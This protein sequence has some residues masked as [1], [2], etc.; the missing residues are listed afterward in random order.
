VVTPDGF[1]VED[2]GKGI[3]ETAMKRLFTPFFTTRARG[4]GLGLCNVKRILD[5]HG[6]RIDVHRLDPG[7][8]FNVSLG[9]KAA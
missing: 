3:D 4:T 8:C 5:A 2:T 7:T 1:R 6:G 9:G